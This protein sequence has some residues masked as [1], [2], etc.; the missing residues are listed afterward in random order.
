M[1]ANV[2]IF[3]VVGL[4]M[5]AVFLPTTVLLLIG[6]LPT[7]VAALVDRSRR[8]TR[9]FTVGAINLA[10]CTPFL[11]EMWME[12]QTF[13]KA[14]SIVLDPTAIIVM[15]AAAA[16][17]YMIDWAMVGIVA[18]VLYQRGLARQEQITK[19]QKELVARWGHEVTGAVPL[20]EKGFPIERLAEQELL[21]NPPAKA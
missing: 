12:G 18:S 2:R 21:R 13:E 11:L 10:G 16:V 4:I 14:I 7:F 3:M 8:K 1:S 19:R 20:D 5:A 17:G 6:M 15:Y 9:A